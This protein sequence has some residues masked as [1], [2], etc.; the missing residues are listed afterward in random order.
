MRL[1]GQRA[2]Y[3]DHRINDFQ[4]AVAAAEAGDAENVRRQSRAEEK[5]RQTVEGLIANL[6]RRFAVRAAGEVPH[7]HRRPR[8]VVR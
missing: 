4:K 1:L 3:I 6:Q 7:T 2:R 5:D 8:Q